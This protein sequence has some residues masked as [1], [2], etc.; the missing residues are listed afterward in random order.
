MFFA[1]FRLYLC[2]ERTGKVQMG[3]DDDKGPKRRSDASFGP[4]VISF[5]FFGFYQY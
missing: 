1:L 4:E 5:N 2:F 3:D